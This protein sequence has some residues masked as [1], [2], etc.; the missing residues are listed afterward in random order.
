MLRFFPLLQVNRIMHLDLK[1]NME[2]LLLI[3]VKMQYTPLFV[4]EGHSVCTVKPLQ[5]HPNTLPT[6]ITG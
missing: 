1:H 4:L 2:D 3:T 6:I 5:Y